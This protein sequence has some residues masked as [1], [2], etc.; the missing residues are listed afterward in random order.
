MDFYS[1]SKADPTLPGLDPKTLLGILAQKI[2]LAEPTLRNSFTNNNNKVTC[3]AKNAIF[4]L[5]LAYSAGRIPGNINIR[6]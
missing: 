4:D 3:Q 1:V 5:Q 2:K 6:T